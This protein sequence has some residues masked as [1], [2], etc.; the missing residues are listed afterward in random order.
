MK[1]AIPTRCRYSMVCAL[2]LAGFWP[3]PAPASD[4]QTPEV[5]SEHHSAAPGHR[6]P[7]GAFVEVVRE[8]DQALP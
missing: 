8:V 1:H 4:G 5:A 2:V 7:A 6:T 3:S